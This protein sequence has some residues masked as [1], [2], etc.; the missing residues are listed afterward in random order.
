VE[1]YG[2]KKRGRDEAYQKK[3]EILPGTPRFLK[4]R[5]KSIGGVLHFGVIDVGKVRETKKKKG[6]NL[7]LGKKH[8]ILKVALSSSIRFASK[9]GSGKKMSSTLRSEEFR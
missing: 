1:K 5:P 6:V 9:I 4:P 7:R 3:R 8:H 2:K